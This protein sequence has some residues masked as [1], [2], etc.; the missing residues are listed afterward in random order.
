M[1]PLVSLAQANK[2]LL[3]YSDTSAVQ[4]GQ[5][6][7]EKQAPVTNDSLHK[8]R[9]QHEGKEISITDRRI[10]ISRTRQNRGMSK[11]VKQ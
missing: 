10:R 5:D 2:K 4:G 6:T 8:E 11:M 3:I 1:K 9:V 7:R